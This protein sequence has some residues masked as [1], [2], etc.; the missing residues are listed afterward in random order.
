LHYNNWIRKIREE[1][2]DIEKAGGYQKM[3]YKRTMERERGRQDY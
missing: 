1:A 2:D 3:I